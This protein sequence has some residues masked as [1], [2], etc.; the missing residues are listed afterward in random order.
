MKEDKLRALGVDEQT[1]RN[2]PAISIIS[3]QGSSQSSA[4][5]S[6]PALASSP[7]VGPLLPSFYGATSL[8]S[9]P[10]KSR[11]SHFPTSPTAHLFHEPSL[12]PSNQFAQPS[13]HHLAGT[14]SPQ[15]YSASQQGPRVAS[16]GVNGHLQ[17]L[18]QIAPSV[19]G[20]NNVG[21]VSEQVSNDLLALA[22]MQQ[23]HHE[24][25]VLQQSS[26]PSLPM[27]Q[28][29]EQPIAH[30]NQ[31]GIT[32]PI[33]RYYRQNPSDILQKGVNEAGA[34]VSDA[35]DGN[36]GQ[37]S[38]KASQLDVGHDEFLKKSASDD[39]GRA[40]PQNAKANGSVLDAGPS[41]EG[42]VD[43]ET[44]HHEQ[45]QS[46]NPSKASQL[47]VNAPEFEPE[48]FKNPGIFSFLGNQH[49]H[50][51]TES[52][53][54]NTPSSC[55]EMQAPDG[56]SQTS[57]WNIAAPT[58]MPNSYKVPTI[59]SREFSF[60]ALRPSLRPDAPVFEPSTAKHVSEPEASNE[61][62]F[63]QPATKIFGDINFAEIIKPPKS[64]AVP[65]TKPNVVSE[66]KST[67]DESMD[68]QEDESG[69][70]TQADG[71]QKRMRYVGSEIHVH[72][73]SFGLSP[74]TFVERM[75]RASFNTRCATQTGLTIQVFVTV[76]SFCNTASTTHRQFLAPECLFS[77]ALP[78]STT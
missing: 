2:S 28:N 7:H 76:M 20:I 75:K 9:Y 35:M 27:S 5:L 47:N 16:P 22:Q 13:E 44:N 43:C 65:I 78:S 8:A 40:A 37:G 69:R 72:V 62:S 21:Q 18:E 24:H 68:G 49:A 50:I 34:Y 4:M 73:M 6:S 31:A 54:L 58:F 26:L 52:E 63:I 67:S 60:S 30:H 15:R 71:R 19:L 66:S 51:V 57:K 23:Q 29:R 17:T 48:V 1:S 56:A 46:R 70:I 39:D 36:G 61:Q 11:I 64:K 53:S 12:M 41:V 25:K 38:S 32:N 59:P 14:R 10:G 33:P 74:T 3:R 77:K 55:L 42:I 45:S